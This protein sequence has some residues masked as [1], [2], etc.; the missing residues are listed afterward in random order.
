MDNRKVIIIVSGISIVLFSF[1]SMQW[2]SGMKKMPPRKPAK[3][4]ARYVK[5]E[6]VEY[7]NVVTEVEIMGRVTSKTEVSLIA[8]VRGEIMNGDI[9][10]KVGES[11]NKGDL[12]VK[13]DDEIEFY[14]M[15]SRKSSFL[16]SVAGML[17]DLKVSLPDNYEEWNSFMESIDIDND[18]PDLPELSST[19]ERVY[20]ASRNIL[21]NYYTIKSAEANFDSYHIYAPFSGT[22]T[23]VSL[24]EG[25][26]ANPGSKLGKII[27][28]KKLELEV[29]VEIGS[30][31]WLKVGQNVKVHDSK[32]TSVWNGII[33]RKSQ[34]VNPATQSI[35]VYVS[36]NST[37]KNPLYK[38]EYLEAN[39]GG[40][41][42]FNVMEIPRKAVFNHNE[43][44]I[45]KDGLLAKR[46]ILIE[47]INKDIIYFSG[48]QNGDYI[49]AQPLI[50]ASENTKVEIL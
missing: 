41:Q 12:L 35:N 19:Q 16:N 17:P 14:N 6:K 11:F 20:M 25:A 13:I 3:E 48:L 23:E 46:E 10:F 43:V 47:K 40:I 33:V 9:S 2:L 18:L 44:F 37:N 42:L 45:V 49:V 5:T 4:V 31:K 39:F 26:I 30:A 36:L 29:P 15:K 24:E 28:T 8:E 22:I 50:N 27:N 38:G 7:K 32:K 34:N 21:T 1:F